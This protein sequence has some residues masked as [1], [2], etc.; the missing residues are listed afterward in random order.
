MSKFRVVV[1]DPAWEFGDNLTMSE[2]K[3]G[4]SSNYDT[5]TIE[6]LKKLPVQDICQEDA[7][8]ALWC[9]SS[10]LSEGLEVMK[11]WG[12]RQTQTHVWVKTK[13]FPLRSLTRELVQTFK[14][15][16]ANASKTNFSGLTKEILGK[17]NLGNLLAFGMGRLFRQ[18]HEVALVGVR[19][20]IY[21]HLE[22]KSQRSVHF[23]P[24][25]KHSTKP[26][27]LQEM[28]E[29]M[30]PNGERLEMFARRSRSGWTC[31]GLE[32]PSTMGEDIR[33]SIDKLK[34]LKS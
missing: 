11:A 15:L 32:C 4:S 17:F 28:L 27:T 8:L 30:F 20:R 19:G 12:F 24:T 16:G 1:A 22:N 18:T 31:V 7:V 25:T 6:D 2:T 9:P 29:K 34:K 23:H 14:Q 13:K 26:E 21:P 3:R 10:L 5:L 33:D